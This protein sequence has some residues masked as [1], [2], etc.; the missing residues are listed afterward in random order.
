[1][2][3]PMGK[4][5]FQKAFQRCALLCRQRVQ[6]GSGIFRAGAVVEKMTASAQQGQFFSI[7][8]ML[9]CFVK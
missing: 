6:Q 5:F 2:L 3:L 9:L 7:L 4:A 1:M 8:Y